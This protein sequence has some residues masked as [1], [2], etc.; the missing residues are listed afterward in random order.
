MEQIQSRFNLYKL[1]L[2]RKYHPGFGIKDG[3]NG[4][5][6]SSRQIT[7]EVNP[8]LFLKADD[9]NV[10]AVRQKESGVMTDWV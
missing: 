9:I 7:C 3:L 5:T 6:T 4:L 8:G 2:L 10:G 1:H